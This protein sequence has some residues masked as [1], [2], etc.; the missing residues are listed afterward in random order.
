LKR[1]RELLKRAGFDWF[2][3]GLIF[4]IFVAYMWPDPGVHDGPLSLTNLAHYGVSF[5]F[6]F[7][8]LKLSP[9][10][11]K[12]GLSSW[13]L[14]I[15]IQLSTFLLFPL[16]ILPFY[17]L[18]QGTEYELLWLGTFYLAALPSTV[19]SSVVMVSIAGGNMPA[20]I[21]NAS[22]SSLIGILITPLWMGLFLTANPAD[23]NL[24]EILGNL[25]LQ[26]LVPVVLGFS[27]NK[28]FG[29]IAEKNKNRLRVFDQI[30]ILLIIYTSFSKSFAENMFAGIQTF[31]LLILGLLMIVLFFAVFFIMN[32]ISR[33]LGFSQEDRITTIFCG[34]KKSLVHGTLMSKVIFPDASLAGIL[35]LPIM[36]YHA[37]QLIFASSIAQIWARKNDVNQI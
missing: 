32:V 17:T 15:V 16:V 34:S 23:F 36:L 25:V 10:K 2:L 19:S 22:I 3:A 27:L 12:S 26:V 11:L 24:W 13:K 6:F 30:V 1:V 35:L 33:L 28:A 21:F 7:Y 4:M 31:D 9:Q 37:L 18:F 20:A 8:G 29:A 5:I 14:H